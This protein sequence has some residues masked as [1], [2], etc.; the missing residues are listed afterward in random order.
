MANF[1]WC[2][3]HSYIILIIYTRIYIHTQWNSKNVLIFIF[4]IMVQETLIIFIH[5]YYYFLWKLNIIF[6]SEFNVDDSNLVFPTL[7]SVDNDAQPIH[8]NV[9]SIYSVLA[10][11]P[12]WLLLSKYG[13]TYDVHG[14]LHN[15]INKIHQYMGII[16]K[17]IIIKLP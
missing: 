7:L 11:Q 17:K 16:S 9:M 6:P 12:Y 1:L 15:I 5:F 2:V 3:T 13:R 14:T 4:I 10:I 8:N